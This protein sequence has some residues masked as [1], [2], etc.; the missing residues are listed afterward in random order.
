[1]RRR[2]DAWCQPHG[3]PHFSA[4]VDVRLPACTVLTG[5]PDYAT[6]DLQATRKAL[7]AANIQ[8]DS[9]VELFGGRTP[10]RLAYPDTTPHRNALHTYDCS[11]WRERCWIA[12]SHPLRSHPDYPGSNLCAVETA[13]T[14]AC[15]ASCT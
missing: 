8:L 9:V 11:P 15:P 1:M 2:C 13:S 14:V 7:L 12:V 4:V 6:A 3:L 5:V 10:R